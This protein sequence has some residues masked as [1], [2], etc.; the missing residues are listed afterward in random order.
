M[1]TMKPKQTT[2]M[3]S[4]KRSRYYPTTAKET[5]KASDKYREARV[6]VG[7]PIPKIH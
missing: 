3:V 1:K 6:S 4:G 5:K 7:K 2:A